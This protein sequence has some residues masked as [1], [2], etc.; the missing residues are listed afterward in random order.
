VCFGNQTW[1]APVS[2]A[3]CGSGDS[4]F[5]GRVKREPAS[6]ETVGRHYYEFFVIMGLSTFDFEN[7]ALSSVQLLMWPSQRCACVA[8]L[9]MWAFQSYA[10]VRVIMI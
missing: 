5:T 9:L 6:C 10:R 2:P 4:C 7:V 1:P 3:T 8:Q